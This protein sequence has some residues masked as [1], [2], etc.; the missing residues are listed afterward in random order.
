MEFLK[1]LT[2]NPYKDLYWNVPEEKK[3][4]RVAVIGGNSQSFRT[5]VKTAEYLLNKFPF[6][7]VKIVLPDS[8]KSKLPAFDNLV[9]LKS[10]EVGSFGEDGR[11][12]DLIDG[13]DASL[14]VGDFSKNSITGKMIQDALAQSSKPVLVTRDT[15]D[16]IA[17]TKLEQILMRPSLTIMGSIV[18]WQKI[19][20]AVYYPKVLMPSQSLVQVA[21]AF[22]KFTLSYPVQIVSLHDGQILVAMNGKVT[23]MPLESS[24]YSPFTVWSGELAGQILALNYYNPDKFMEATVSAVMR[25]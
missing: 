18:Q 16:L 14:M 7:E 25:T 20:K 4:G 9:F 5:P 21:E 22:H 13:V 15:I 2:K 3:I 1:K 11:L 23:V 10:T 19:L 12:K 17:E 8:L 6:E 24:G